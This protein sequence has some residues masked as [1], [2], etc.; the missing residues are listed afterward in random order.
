MDKLTLEQAVEQHSTH[1]KSPVGSRL[2]IYKAEAF[3]A[4]AEW[5]KEQFTSDLHKLNGLQIWINDKAMK[6][7]FS[8]FINK[9]LSI[10]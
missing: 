4:G 3:K 8:D 1:E 10:P 5:Q 6:N 7:L 2:Y 9:Y